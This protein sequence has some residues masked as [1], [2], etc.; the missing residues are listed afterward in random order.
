MGVTGC[1]EVAWWLTAQQADDP[2]FRVAMRELVAADPLDLDAVASLVATLEPRLGELVREEFADL[3]RISS[4]TVLRSW[5]EAVKSE[6][7][8]KLISERPESPMDFARRRCISVSTEVDDWGITVRLSPFRRAT[9]FE[10][11]RKAS[12][13][14]QQER[15]AR[16]LL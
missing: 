10:W 5:L 8:F 4:A 7:P 6:L 1:E 2:V 12:R 16:W 3:P 14:S 9:R 13:S 15:M 11:L